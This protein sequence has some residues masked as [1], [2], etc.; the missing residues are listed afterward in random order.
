MLAIYT[1]LS[2]EDEYSNSIDNQIREGEMFAKEFEFDNFQVYNEGE[3]LSGGLEIEYRPELNKL[4]NDIVS[5]VVTAVWYRSQ[6]RLERNT[7]TFQTFVHI[8]KKAKVDVYVGDKLVDYND[9]N[10]FF[11]S[12]ISSAFNQL[13]KDL[14]SQQTKK[15][16][17]L[18]FLDGKTHGISP[19]GYTK[20]DNNKLV[21]D[22]E[23]ADIIKRIYDLS[24][25]GVGTNKIAE[26]F[27]NEGI[28]TRYNKIGKGTITTTNKFTKRKKITLKKDIRWAG[29]TV[30]GVIINS[31]NKGLRLSGGEE[32]KVEAII[33][34]D[35]WQLVNDNLSKNRN[36]SGKRV[37][38]KYLLKGFITCGKCS[39]NMY[40]KTRV[41]K[42]DNY[43]MCS[44]KRIKNENCKNRSIN[45]DKFDAF[46]F[47]LLEREE[48][49]RMAA[50]EYLNKENVSELI[51]DLENKFKN[52]EKRKEKLK[53]KKKNLLR[54]AMKEFISDEDFN[55]ENN[56]L[57]KRIK[58][59]EEVIKALGREI[60]NLKITIESKNTIIEDWRDVVLNDLSFTRKR[61]LIN[62]TI[63]RIYVFFDTKSRKYRIGVKY[64]IVPS[65]VFFYLVDY[66]CQFIG[67]SS[68]C[69]DNGDITE[70]IQNDVNFS[71]TIPWDISYSKF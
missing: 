18:N 33:D 22:E 49:G 58:S 71:F 46:I 16:I 55:N 30:R 42:K 56:I 5:G 43:Y 2:R 39:R 65:R 8:V 36:N 40:G 32:Y 69:D 63:D 15:A 13:T 31:I 12:T 38:H 11:Q 1:R 47:D 4:V 64:K 50:Y 29:N 7:F 57:L 45:I 62:D 3:G 54:L 24:L 25:K 48:F 9:A 6:S 37:S 68:S 10:T 44:S 34:E 35:Y 67:H 28:Q 41:S 61:E 51:L 27:N 60:K 20:G 19:Y 52:E 26:I 23:E 21:I 14:Q 17:K 59:S 53:T 70:Y 66:K